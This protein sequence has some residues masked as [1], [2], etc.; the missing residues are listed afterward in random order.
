MIQAMR[1]LSMHIMYM[2]VGNVGIL[3]EIIVE[4]YD[5]KTH[6]QY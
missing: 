3:V 2:Y 5:G 6:L 4:S 1:E